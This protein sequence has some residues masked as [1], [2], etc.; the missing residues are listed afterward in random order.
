MPKEIST[1]FLHDTLGLLLIAG[2]VLIQIEARVWWSWHSKRAKLDAAV[3]SGDYERRQTAT[4]VNKFWKFVFQYAVVFLVVVVSLAAVAG[5]L[6]KRRP[7]HRSRMVCRL[8]DS[9]ALSNQ[10]VAERAA[11]TAVRLD[12]KNFEAR[13]TLAQVLVYRA[14][15]D[16]ALEE[17]DKIPPSSRSVSDT[18]IKAQAL[19]GKKQLDDAILLI[20]G[21]AEG[22]KRNP[23]VAMF[24]AELAAQRGDSK[25]VAS[26]V[27][28]ANEAT[29]STILARIRNLF[30]YL[31]S[32]GEW[33]TIIDCDRPLPYGDPVQAAIV[34][35]AYLRMNM[36]PGMEKS[37]RSAIQLWPEH[38]V[39]LYH[40]LSIAILRPEGKWEDLFAASYLRNLPRLNA[41]QLAIYIQSCFQLRRPDLAWL[42]Y[43][44]L[45]TIDPQ[46]P[47]LSYAASTFASVWFTFKAKALGVG[48]ANQNDS[49]NLK[50]VYRQAPNVWPLSLLWRNVPLAQEMAAN[51]ISAV[52]EKYL[53][54]YTGELEHR[55]MTTNGLNPRMETLLTTTLIRTGKYKEAI[56]RLDKLEKAA[57]ERQLEVLT[58]R[59]TIS[60]LQRDWDNSYELSRQCLAL[61]RYSNVA[62]S[63]SQMNALINLRFPMYALTLGE[64][65]H[66]AMPD[67]PESTLTLVVLR[68]MF[69][70]REEAISLLDEIPEA[71]GSPIGVKVLYDTER[72]V[73]ADKSAIS[74][75]QINQTNS[76]RQ[77]RL[78]MP[79]AEI[80]I[81]PPKPPTMPDDDKIDQ[82]ATQLEKEAEA[83]SSS[84]VSGVKRLIAN[85]HRCRGEKGSSDPDK[86]EK[87]GRDDTERAVSLN[88]LASLLVF[89]NKYDEANKVLAMATALLPESPTLWKQRVALTA[90][91][92]EVIKMARKVYPASSDLWLAELVA[93][94]R[95]DG[96]GE[97]A[98]REIQ[99]AT[100]TQKF[101]AGAIVM[102]GDFLGR[103]GMTNAAIVAAKYA[104]K[105][106]NGLLPAYVLGL[107]CALVS[108][109]MEWALQCASQA[110]GEAL[111]PTPFEKTI[112]ELQMMKGRPTVNLTSM[113]NKLR[114]KFPDDPQ[115]GERLGIVNFQ[116][117]DMSA[118]FSELSPMIDKGLMGKMTGMGVLMAAEAAHSEGHEDKAIE[119]LEQAYATH[120]N[121]V[122]VLNNL[123]YS[124]AQSPKTLPRAQALLPRML[125]ISQKV[126]SSSVYDTIATVY[127]KTG[128]FKQAAE[129]TRKALKLVRPG[130]HSAD[131]LHLNAAEIFIQMGEFKEA[132]AELDIVSRIAH[133]SKEVED[134]RRALVTALGT[135]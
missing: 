129:F 114:A 95:D 24:S 4:H 127:F 13:R 98:M 120:T 58:Q 30:P 118:A 70:S 119:I 15:N 61:M 65:L 104:I 22:V 106:A 83:S 92:R 21:L 41:D 51:D 73:E 5:L 108:N 60:D 25:G 55:D 122:V 44:R 112:V 125:L 39:F 6:Y 54:I 116:N 69:G 100:E 99:Q 23:S 37:L 19:A 77:Q 46:D 76:P 89:K 103:S 126:E 48:A 131:E 29:S 91:N 7:H 81:T 33:K 86:W 57:P 96:P 82:A 53:G 36:I 71:Y 14:K 12:G 72:F 8:V 75:A 59:L 32:R 27:I 84:F 64:S 107:R 49:V 90:G 94:K 68:D 63:R 130:D 67:S 121:N 50:K 56:Q 113:L 3:K 20:N 85:W 62:V 9:L 80:M 43:K 74:A 38:P 42:A 11:T 88:N 45:S 132:R 93:R 31:A 16:Q 115:W 34:V 109:D 117:N 123:I 87:I 35:E 124:L 40:L 79:M 78:V 111:D 47:A 101:P 102:A 128:K 2:I 66:K 97:W 105:H 1:S 135:R 17:L 18:I 26:N 133:K 134:R 52:S 28:L 10:E 110:A